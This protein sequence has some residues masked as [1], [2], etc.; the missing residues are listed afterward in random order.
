MTRRSLH[1]PLPAATAL[2]VAGSLAAGLA[3]CS[4]P[5]ASAPADDTD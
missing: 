1:R 2:L 3:A 4:G 5:A